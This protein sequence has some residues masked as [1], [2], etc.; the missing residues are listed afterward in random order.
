[1]Y[2]RLYD[3]YIIVELTN[4]WSDGAPC[5]HV[6]EHDVLRGR[7]E[8]LTTKYSI[9][10]SSCNEDSKHANWS[11]TDS[12]IF[13]TEVRYNCESIYTKLTQIFTSSAV[14]HQLYNIQSYQ[15]SSTV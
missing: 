8:Q 5:P 10:Q 12:N 1:M 14:S 2:K 4:D 3:N 6:I 11:K 9:I 15:T 13:D 7:V